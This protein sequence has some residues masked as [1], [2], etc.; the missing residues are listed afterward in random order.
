MPI[1][2]RLNSLVLL[3]DVLGREAFAAE[4]ISQAAARRILTEPL[5]RQVAA[6]R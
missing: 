5:A 1:H 3:A 2:L 6:L 4:A